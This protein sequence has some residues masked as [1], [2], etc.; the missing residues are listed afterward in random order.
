MLVEAEDGEDVGEAEA[1]A[2]VS[3]VDNPNGYVTL[4][5]YF[6]KLNVAVTFYVIQSFD[7]PDIHA[8]SVKTIY[9]VLAS[10]SNFYRFFSPRS[11]VFSH[12]GE[13]VN[14]F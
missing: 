6:K 14:T 3:G 5:Y 12:S 11:A 2:V 10:G 4:L 9:R 1:E 7:S 8:S 13:I